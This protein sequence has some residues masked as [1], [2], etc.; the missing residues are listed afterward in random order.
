L[1]RQ[2]QWWVLNLPGDPV[3]QDVGALKAMAD[4]YR[5]FAEEAG[6]AASGSSALVADPAIQN[7]MG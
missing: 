2:T 7:W 3:P 4:S 1:T 6:R 5:H